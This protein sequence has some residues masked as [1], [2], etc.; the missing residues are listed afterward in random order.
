[1]YAL[2]LCRHFGFTMRELLVVIAA[3]ALILALAIPACHDAGRGG[4]SRATG[5]RNNLKTFALS[6]ISF[7]A[8]NGHY[9]DY[10]D[11][12]P[13]PDGRRLSRPLMYMILPQL[14]RSDLYEAGSA[15]AH[16]HD[17][18]PDSLSEFLL[19]L[20]LCPSVVEKDKNAKTGTAMSYVVNAGMPDVPSPDCPLDW[21]ANGVFQNRSWAAAMGHELPKNNQ[22]YV[23]RHD[24]LTNT[25]MWS[26]RLELSRWTDT[27]EYDVAFVW[28]P[29]FAENPLARINSQPS[30]RY[31]ASKFVL[32]R[33]SS[34]HPGRVNVAFCDGHVRSI[35]DSIDYFVY[36]QLMTPNGNDA[37]YAGIGGDK[38]QRVAEAFRQ[39]LPEEFQ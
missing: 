26:E 29:Q 22:A 13:H 16:P 6:V 32:A 37:A 39:A 20:T 30:G 9:P 14:E 25:L 7:E 12:L 15:M 34:H 8:T 23:E 17:G 36:S 24:G 21:P 35:S 28:H 1:V 33:P 31:A 3:I 10:H 4:S 5:C 2:R 11:S 38:P 18:V 27:A 19:P